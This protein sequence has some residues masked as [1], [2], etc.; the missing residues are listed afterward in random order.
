MVEVKKIKKN[1]SEREF[2]L[3]EYFSKKKDWRI[4]IG[5]PGNKQ[6]RI[7]AA[8]LFK[9]FGNRIGVENTTIEW[10]KKITETNWRNCLEQGIVPIGFF[11]DGPFGR[12]PGR[13]ISL[14]EKMI[15]FLC[16]GNKDIKLFQPLARMMTDQVLQ[17]NHSYGQLQSELMIEYLERDG[18]NFEEQVKI[19]SIVIRGWHQRQK[20]FFYTKEDIENA[21]VETVNINSKK[22]RI[23]VVPEAQSERTASTVLSGK[24]KLGKID[25]YIN[26]LAKNGRIAVLTKRGINLKEAV[27]V[28]RIR[29]QPKMGMDELQE[30]KERPMGN[31]LGWFFTRSATEEDRII[32]DKEFNKSR[33]ELP[34]GLDE[35]A[36]IVKEN[37][38]LKNKK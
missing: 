28:L 20:E 3:E 23:C 7:M 30:L 35:V 2:L 1:V 29:T 27:E 31:V 10:Q 16:W 8:I 4:V 6:D 25:I 19:M 32:Y 34:F 22:V 18:I 38:Q 9:E 5:A 14:T 11:K 24:S 21:R 12:D 15:E 36:K 13:D 26:K 33:P 17:Q 37:L